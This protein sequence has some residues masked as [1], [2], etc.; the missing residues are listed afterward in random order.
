MSCSDPTER[1][2]ASK[3]E[4]LQSSSGLPSMDT[5]HQGSS[6]AAPLLELARGPSATPDDNPARSESGYPVGL[7]SLETA[8]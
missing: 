2:S 7:Q 5:A 3:G 8:S 6:S 4:N 1:I